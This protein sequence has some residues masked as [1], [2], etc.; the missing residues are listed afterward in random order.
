MTDLVRFTGNADLEVRES[1]DG[2]ASRRE[3]FGRLFEYG[4]PGQTD[5]GPE[6]IERGALEG[7]DPES[8][9]FRLDHADPLTGRM[10]AL[11]DRE[12]GPYGT[13]RV[14]DTPRGDEQLELVRSGLYK[15]LSVGFVR[16]PVDK[17]RRV[18]G[19]RTGVRSRIELREVSTTWRP[20]HPGAAILA[21]RAGR[22]GGTDVSDEP[23]SEPT[24]EPVATP[25]RS[26]DVDG[27]RLDAILTRLEAIETRSRQD[28]V[29]LP[30][31]VPRTSAALQT[32]DGEISELSGRWAALAL[33]ALAGERPDEL[34]LRALADIIT[35]PN[36]G[37]VPDSVRTE[38]IGLID[39]RRPFLETTREVP[40]GSS[41]LKITF[42]RIVTR[43]VTAKQTAEKAEVA[44]GATAIDTVE[45]GSATIAGAGDLSVQLLRRSSPAF[46]NLWLE[47]LAEQYAKD[48]DT[49]ALTS[50]LAAGV[51]AGT[52]T[53]NPASPSFAEAW[54][55]SAV[56]VGQPMAPDR[57]WLSS[58]A[59][60]K[61]ID[62][63]S[64]A[65]GGGVPLYPGLAG[66]SGISQPGGGGPVPFSMRPVWV[67]ALDPTAVDVRL[68][69]SRGFA[70]AEDGTFTL[71]ADV[72][73]KLGRDVALAGMLWCM[74]VYPA[75][76]TTY[77]IAP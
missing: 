22:N 75:A 43:P 58:A 8:V 27:A 9:M 38:L 1:T 32:F 71:Q 7:T 68:G 34:E 40:S 44:S 11:E 62:A 42:P 45:F 65:G 57:I 52:G 31:G 61:F 3:V 49:E 25:P 69:P 20:A 4:V 26:P 18:K 53:F 50:L 55:N 15:G 66:M 12:D 51:Q 19:K 70:W 35:T 47:L 56:E 6:I 64:P 36:L 2:P 33:T 73:A 48:A 24:D 28:G 77:A 39:N 63:K 60:A 17:Y 30:A 54:T 13:F 23:V 74:P 76:F 5:E 14:A 29:E 59:M 37:V 10:V 21:I 72:P 41:G 16:A 67:P 46:L